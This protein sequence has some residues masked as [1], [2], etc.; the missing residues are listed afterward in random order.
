MKISSKIFQ[1]TKKVPSE[2]RINGERVKSAKLQLYFYFKYFMWLFPVNNFLR[3]LLCFYRIFRFFPQSFSMQNQK[4]EEFWKA[5]SLLLLL[6]FQWFLNENFCKH[7]DDDGNIVDSTSCLK[8][9]THKVKSF[10]FQ[11]IKHIFKLK[12]ST[13][14]SRILL[15]VRTTCTITSIIKMHFFIHA[16]NNNNRVFAFVL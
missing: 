3:F 4:N 10:F 13:T 2:K 5:I 11:K 1:E 9:K 8:H 14:E 6:L 15:V 16:T 12:F 7:E